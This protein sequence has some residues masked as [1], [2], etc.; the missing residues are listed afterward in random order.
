MRTQRAKRAYPKSSRRHVV[1]DAIDSHTNVLEAL[2]SHS[3]HLR[4]FPKDYK[5]RLNKGVCL[6]KLN[7]YQEAIE[8]LHQLHEDHP[9]DTNVL[10]LCGSLYQTI[11]QPSLAG[12][13]FKRAINLNENDYESWIGLCHAANASMKDTDALQYA[14]KALALRPTDARSHNN[15]GA[16]LMSLAKHE[17]ATECYKTALL[18]DPNNIEALSNLA[19]AE[20]NS[21][22]LNKAKAMHEKALRMVSAESNVASEIRYKLSYVQLEMGNFKEGWTN[23]NE[24]L[25]VKNARARLPQR[26]FNIPLWSGQRLN[27]ER[28]LVWRE[29]GIGDEIAF[30]RAL[31][32]ALE[33]CKNITIQCEPR[34]SKLISRSFPACE[35]MDDPTMSGDIANLMDP[36]ADYHV[37]LGTLF[38]Y[39]RQSK[40]D[41]LNAGPYLQPDPVLVTQFKERLSSY[42]D[43]KLVGICWR[44]GKLSAERNKHYTSLSDWEEI[45]SLPNHAFVNLQ[46]GDCTEEIANAK[47]A[48]GVDILQ[49]NDVDLKDDQDAL[50]AIISNLDLVISV[51]TAVSTLAQNIGVT[52][53]LMIISNDWTRLGSGDTVE[54][55]WASHVTP[56]IPQANQP[57]SSQISR[58]AHDLINNKH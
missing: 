4:Q 55:L 20:Q 48:F 19:V 33:F 28:L 49:W 56:Y 47:M 11:G 39:F 15:L 12:R 6:A 27:H 46:Y 34:L 31:P 13:F 24:G 51:G 37:P 25:K 8:V 52:Q 40:E 32:Q 44:S 36:N 26:K 50:A 1:A 45:L 58:I 18:L 38:G 7:R 30:Y 53:K 16:A 54:Y 10:R 41:F 57:M 14:M 29:Q 3:K 5:A 42:K 17:E 21:G 9:N 35:V 22:N 23:Y 2:N 43:K